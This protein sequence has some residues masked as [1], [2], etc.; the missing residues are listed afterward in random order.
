MDCNN[1]WIKNYTFENFLLGSKT[2]RSLPNAD[3]IIID[4]SCEFIR[5]PSFFI[6]SNHTEFGSIWSEKALVHAQGVVA[7]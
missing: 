2:Q 1:S 4:F 7:V 5:F 6:Y 3:K